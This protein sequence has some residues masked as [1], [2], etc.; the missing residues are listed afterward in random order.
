MTTMTPEELD[1]ARAREA[2]RQLYGPE[3]N[4]ASHDRVSTLAARLAREGWTPVD[5]DL[6]QAREIAAGTHDGSSEWA[7]GAKKGLRD[8]SRAVQL[9]LAGIKRGRELERGAI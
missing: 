5:P 9:V 3:A 2:L 1:E 4:F 7:D 8:D 6:I